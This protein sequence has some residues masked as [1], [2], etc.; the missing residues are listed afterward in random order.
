[1]NQSVR[2]PLLKL[3]VV[4]LV[5]VLAIALIYSTLRNTVRG[6]T[7][8]YVAEFAD[9]TGLREGD[10]VRMAGVKVGRIESMALNGTRA[11]VSFSVQSDQT[12]FENTRALI[13]YQNLVGQRYLALMPGE[14]ATRPL[15]AGATIPP[16]RTE[17]SLDLTALLNG[18]EPLFAMLQP[19]DL[20]RL[21]TTIIQALQGEGPA[22]NS[23]LEQSA[24]LS[25]RFAD[26]DQVLGNVLTGLTNVLGHLASKG[27]EF[28]ELLA[29]AQR[30]VS[31]INGHSD[32]IFGSLQKIDTASQSVSGLLGDIR[33]AL[34]TDLARFNQ[35]AGLFLHEGP[36]V[37]GTVRALPGFLGGLARVSQYGSWLNLYACSLDVNLPPLPIG[38]LPQLTGGKQSEVCQ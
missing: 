22:L 38:V 7:T 27:P 32:Q 29:Q 21:S 13:R 10:D 19:D 34:R 20:N 31:G 33:P 14:G 24:Q 15:S 17:P 16:Q 3:T 30:L 28:D 4:A 8:D 6:D 9:V 12:V 35:V 5:S 37:E 26:R 23:L 11:D 1:M 18:F 25:T 2:G 36:A